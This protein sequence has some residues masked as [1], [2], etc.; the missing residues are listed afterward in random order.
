M[1][2]IQTLDGVRAKARPFVEPLPLFCYQSPKG[3]HALNAH[4]DVRTF[5]P[6]ISAES[7]GGEGTEDDKPRDGDEAASSIAASIY[8][9][10]CCGFLSLTF[11]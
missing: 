1:P 6:F 11:Y 8:T 7:D 5:T 10:P 3:L 2:P 9:L 4:D